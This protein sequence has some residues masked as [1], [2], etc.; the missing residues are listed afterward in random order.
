MGGKLEREKPVSIETF[1]MMMRRVVQVNVIWCGPELPDEAL[2]VF[3]ELVVCSFSNSDT[4]GKAKLFQRC[5]RP[6]PEGAEPE[7]AQSREPNNNAKQVL[8]VCPRYVHDGLWN[9]GLG[10]WLKVATRPTSL[11]RIPDYVDG[12]YYVILTHN[13]K[14]RRSRVIVDETKGST[15][16][17]F[18]PAAQTAVGY[19]NSVKH[20]GS[21]RIHSDDGAFTPTVDDYQRDEPGLPRMITLRHITRV[22][23]NGE[24]INKFSS[25]AA[26]YPGVPRIPQVLLRRDDR[27]NM[28]RSD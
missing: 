13:M 21:W 8:V 11:L 6:T 3:E 15:L 19:S 9:G 12:T 28:T 5:I 22:V 17:C 26:V 16:Y 20:W 4:S 24:R 27:N 14:H 10:R 25:H 18:A 1:S 23:A 7:K 2:A